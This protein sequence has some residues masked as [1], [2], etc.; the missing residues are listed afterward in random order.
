MTT[1]FK[2]KSPQY[3][4][5]NYN[6]Y[7]YLGLGSQLIVGLLVSLYIGKKFDIYFNHHAFFAWMAPSI[8]ILI[9]LISIVRDTQKKN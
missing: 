6:W 1:K 8:F 9:V 3:Q 4:Q 5:P 7:K 2:E